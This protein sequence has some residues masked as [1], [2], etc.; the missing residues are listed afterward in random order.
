VQEA[1]LP[2][3]KR[4]EAWL[5]FSRDILS[6]PIG[7]SLEDL[8]EFRYIAKR[9]NPALLDIIEEYIRLSHRS[10]TEVSP[11][12]IGSA[13]KPSDK[14]MHLFD[15]LREKT[16]FPQNLDL[17]RFAERVL[18][19][20]RA[21]RFDKM[22]RSDIAARIIE[23]IES[24]PASRENLERSMREALTNVGGTP[25]AETERRSFLSKWERIIKG[26]EA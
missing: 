23:Y 9:D 12:R 13:K 7:R 3:D 6:I 21:Y 1:K 2:I 10:Q 8:E 17:A 24:R 5:R 26:D 18:P 16:F 15:L 25:P 22:S 4:H 19:N 11:K 20:M 14:E